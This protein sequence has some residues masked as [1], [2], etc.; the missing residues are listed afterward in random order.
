MEK[1]KAENVTEVEFADEET[2]LVVQIFVGI[3]TDSN[4]SELMRIIALI[5]TAIGGTEV[6]RLAKVRY[7]LVDPDA[8]KCSTTN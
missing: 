8:K 5:N 4:K 3:R 6:P 2:G 1:P 7:F